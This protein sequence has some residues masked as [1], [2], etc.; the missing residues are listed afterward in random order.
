MIGIRVIE[1]VIPEFENSCFSLFFQSIVSLFIKWSHT[2]NQDLQSCKFLGT[3]HYPCFINSEIIV[4]T[5][6][7]R[8]FT[9]RLFWITNTHMAT[10]KHYG[11]LSQPGKRL[12]LFESGFRCSCRPNDLLKVACVTLLIVDLMTSGRLVSVLLSPPGHF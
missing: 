12:S 1:A 10:S 7:I 3:F 4:I 11:Q 8:L 6:V 2:D 5:S 9:R